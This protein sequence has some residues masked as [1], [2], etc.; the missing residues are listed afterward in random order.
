MPRVPEQRGRA[1]ALGT[2]PNTVALSI[3]ESAGRTR[4]RVANALATSIVLIPGQIVRSA[5]ADAAFI[6]HLVVRAE[7]SPRPGGARVQSRG[8]MEARMAVGVEPSNRE[9]RLRLARYPALA[10]A[11]AEAARGQAVS[12]FRIAVTASHSAAALALAHE[13]PSTRL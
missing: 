5:E 8:R 1:V 9:Y 2:D 3:Y 7:S 13:G 10:L 11:V 6:E 4:A 12:A